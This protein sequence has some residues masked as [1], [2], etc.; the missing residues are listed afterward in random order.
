MIWQAPENKALGISVIKTRDSCDSCTSSEGVV[1]EEGKKNNNNN[2]PPIVLFN[3]ACA[4]LNERN[5][6]PSYFK[7]PHQE[8]R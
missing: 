1:T 7:S 5:A 2:K 3:R 8:W 4:H 6:N